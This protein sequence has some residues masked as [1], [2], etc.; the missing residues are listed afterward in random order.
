MNKETLDKRSGLSIASL[1]TGILSIVLVFTGGA[2]SVAGIVLGAIDLNRIKTGRSSE[3][4]KSFDIAGIVCGALGIVISII[5]TI[6]I[7]VVFIPWVIT[8]FG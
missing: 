2:L 1:V 7:I 4:G 6:V 8:T 5:M 3:I